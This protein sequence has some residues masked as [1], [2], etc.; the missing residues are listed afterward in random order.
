MPGPRPLPRRLEDSL[1]LP[2]LGL[3]ED[4]QVLPLDALFSRRGFCRTLLQGAGASSLVA[5]GLGGCGEGG[6]GLPSLTGDGG[7][8][9][10]APP[11]DLSHAP[12]PDLSEAPADLTTSEPPDLSTGPRD[13]AHNP[14]AC[15]NGVIKTNRAPGAFAVN[16]ATYLA[17]GALFVCRDGGGMFAVTAVCTH[18]GTIITAQN[19]GAGGYRCP[20]HGS[21]FTL[22][23]T[24]TL[25]PNNSPA[26]SVADLEH[27]ALCLDGNGNVAAS[28]NQGV[29]AGVRYPF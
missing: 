13:L 17:A 23:G 25:G 3:L 19:G 12:S 14:F 24:N 28:A 11:R 18:Q 6:G 20:S 29:G 21:R 26:G 10:L 5:L 15:G 7:A 1:K 27:L 9:D 2:R 16:T 8:R 4:G 22:D